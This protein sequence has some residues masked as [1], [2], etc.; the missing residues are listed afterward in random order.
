MGLLNHIGIAHKKLVKGCHDLAALADGH[1]WPMAC[2]A[3]ISGLS[4]CERAQKPS[5]SSA[6]CPKDALVHTRR[7]SIVGEDRLI[8]VRSRENRQQFGNR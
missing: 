2:G 6:E 1:T 7:V 4:T 3:P 5:L 8:F